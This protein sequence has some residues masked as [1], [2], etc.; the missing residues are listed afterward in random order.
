MYGKTAKLL[1]A[2]GNRGKLLEHRRLLEALPLE[3]TWPEREGV[4]LHVEETGETMAE[5]AILK[6]RA[7]AEASGLLTWADDSG[8]EVDALH[9]EPGV[10]SARYAGTNASDEERCRLLLS[11]LR[12]VPWEERTARFRCVVALLEPSGGLHTAEGVC[13]GIITLEPR[14]EGGFGY[15]PLFFLPDQEQTMAELS[16]QEKNVISHRGHAS[17]A[18]RAILEDLLQPRTGRSSQ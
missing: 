15:D 17:H 7:Y 8:L 12:G 9:G 10:R 14:G 11:H 1:V 4:H 16:L 6:V 5:N 3:V 18:A 13:E 2:T